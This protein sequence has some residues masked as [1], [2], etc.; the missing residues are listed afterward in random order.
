MA[1]RSTFH[2]FGGCFVRVLVLCSSV[3]FVWCCFLGV[4]AG[5][6]KIS[7]IYYVYKTLS[8]L[9]FCICAGGGCLCCL[10]GVVGLVWCVVFVWVVVFCNC[11]VYCLG[12]V[13][14]FSCSFSFFLFVLVLV[15]T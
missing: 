14:L 5:L 3:V 13:L 12:V 8:K 11:F 4:F 10:F 2:S 6:F 7:F 9:L 15:Y 1:C